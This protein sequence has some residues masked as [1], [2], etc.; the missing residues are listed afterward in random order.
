MPLTQFSASQLYT[1]WTMG[2]ANLDGKIDSADLDFITKFLDSYHPAADITEDGYVN[3]ADLQLAASNY[4][5]TIYAYYHTFDYDL[6]LWGAIGAFALI[7]SATVLSKLR[8][9]KKICDAD[10]GI[11]L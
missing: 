10:L 6:L 11:N 3:D 5:L 7:G 1:W 8:G 9:R 2:D 4:G